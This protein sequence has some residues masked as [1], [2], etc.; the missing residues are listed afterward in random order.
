MGPDAVVPPPP[1]G[2]VLEQQGPPPPPPGFVLEQQPAPQT[3]GPLRSLGV[4]A[5]GVARGA[6][7]LLGAPVDIGTLAIN[8]ALGLGEVVPNLFLSDEN[9]IT[10]P[11]ITNPVGGSEWIANQASQGYEAA[12][13]PLGELAEPS[14]LPF[15]E[16]AVYNTSRFGSQ[17]A[18]AATGLAKA[19][20]NRVTSAAQGQLPRFTDRFLSPYVGN[21]A[22]RT[23]AADTIG[24]AGVGA[25]LT[26]G[27]EY[28][29]DNPWV[30][31]ATM[32]AGGVLGSSAGAFAARAGKIPQTLGTLSP[33]PT[34]PLVPGS[35]EAPSRAVTN[36]A[37][38]IMQE[39]ASSPAEA[40]ATL[41]E[42]S[43]LA[44]TYGDPMATSGIASDDT[45]L[46]GLERSFRLGDK[47]MRTRRD[48]IDS[49]KAVK[50][51]AGD[52]VEG[53]RDPNADHALGLEQV[54]GVET[55]MEVDR[56]A[57]ALP[58]LERVKQ[59]TAT[60][61]T[62]PVVSLIDSTLSEAKRPAVRGA[63]EQAREMLN[64]PGGTDVDTS[65]AGLYETR[66]AIS[67]IVDGRTDNPTGKYAKSELI[68]VRNELD[69]QIAAVESEFDDYLNAYR[70]GSEPLNEASSTPALSRLLDNDIDLRNTAKRLL[71]GNEYGRDAVMKQIKEFA[72][73]DPEAGRAWRA[74]VADVLA[75]RVQNKAKDGELS[76][77]Q[78]RGVYRDHKGT[79]S[80][81]F[82]PEDM[83]VLERV[84]NMLAPMQNLADTVVPG[85]ATAD[86]SKLQQMM[87]AAI[88]GATGNAITTGMVMK[89]INMGA[90][91]L[92]LEK[93][94]IDYKALQLVKRMQFDPD[95]ARMMLDRP[96]EEGTGALW[97]RDV[98]RLLMGTELSR[99]LSAEED[100]DAELMGAIE[101]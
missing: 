49:D 29:P 65:V 68:A 44:K 7:D 100:D 33:D 79:L 63:L 72:D 22:G 36:K 15:G 50:R 41:A 16:R 1:P 80:E 62:D 9:E 48:F 98:R 73:Y 28:A 95:L 86:N 89:R 14:E 17:A 38:R 99:E 67:D 45:G 97:T 91:L 82:S 32:F 25:G 54:R 40:S 5:Q 37:S 3:G 74:A 84:D 24:G 87:E 101:E 92:G 57:A 23:V 83:E 64:V 56:D 90:A 60:V 52:L 26:V 59:S 51:G 31:L 61:D 78:I 58:I 81:V 34:I 66:K 8:A 43:R 69:R 20:A 77:A 47:D 96:L 21:E 27:E 4:G 10:L 94:T 46:I 70:S 75:D 11:Q 6:A 12:G 53:L 71:A 35:L 30:Q 2:F 19:A 42:R 85:S 13:S 39:A 88:L 18:V 76:I 55:A 93:H